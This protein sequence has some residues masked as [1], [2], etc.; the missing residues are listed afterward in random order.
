VSSRLA[1]LLGFVSGFALVTGFAAW[2][3]YE[4]DHAIR[5]I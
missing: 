2:F 5:Q 4:L 3:G 1:L